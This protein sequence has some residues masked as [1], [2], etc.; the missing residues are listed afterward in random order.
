MGGGH[1]VNFSKWQNEEYDTLVDE[2]AVTPPEDQ[3]AL[4]ALFRQTMEIWLP[5]L[6]DI[7]IQEWYHRI[8]MN[9]TVWSGWPTE[10]DPYVNGAFWHLTFQLILNRLTP[11]G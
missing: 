1:L 10:Q 3:E 11:T 5:E 8:P 6:P 7:Q 2:I 4:L 9:T